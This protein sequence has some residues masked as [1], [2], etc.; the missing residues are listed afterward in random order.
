MVRILDKEEEEDV[1]RRSEISAGE[2]YVMR[3]ST[4]NHFYRSS[5]RCPMFTR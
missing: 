1:E 2:F 3:R 4:C 5:N